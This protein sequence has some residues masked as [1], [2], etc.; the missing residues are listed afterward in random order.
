MDS[1]RET[2]SLRVPLHGVWS[3]YPPENNAEY[4]SKTQ[5]F[6]SSSDIEISEIGSSTDSK[7]R[8][9][10][11]L[12][13][14]YEAEA[15]VMERRLGSLEDIRAKL[16]LSQR[17]IAQLLLVDPSA[18][19]RWTQDE[20]GAPPHVWRALTWYMALQE[21][22]PALDAA[23]WIHSVANAG[24]KQEATEAAIAATR[25][26]RSE[27]LELRR[28]VERLKQ[29]IATSHVGNEGPGVPSAAI[30][31]SDAGVGEL[32]PKTPKMVAEE[33]ETRAI[34]NVF[35]GLTLVGLGYAIAVFFR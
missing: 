32:P 13:Q 20:G 14:K 23:F 30:L 10:S 1:E 24:A 31:S 22:F 33:K 27:V 26:Q 2:E 19:T 17:K 11:S 4:A 29:R 3:G 9:R 5:D 25:A 21:K 18:W 8:V 7:P 28:E 34:A 35:L 12:R 15:R 6:G 16:G